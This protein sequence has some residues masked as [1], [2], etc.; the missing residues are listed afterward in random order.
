MSYRK[1]LTTALSHVRFILLVPL[2]GG[3]ASH[4]VGGGREKAKGRRVSKQF[5]LE[6]KW[7]ATD[8]PAKRTPAGFIAVPSYSMFGTLRKTVLKTNRSQKV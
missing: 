7:P 4:F 1:S 2:P 8:I 5:I 6:P 3:G